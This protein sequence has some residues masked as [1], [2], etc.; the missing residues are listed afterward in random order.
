MEKIIRVQRDQGACPRSH[1]MSEAELVNSQAR[2][3]LQVRGQ[4]SLKRDR[5]DTYRF[6]FA[7][8]LEPVLHR[9]R[10]QPILVGPLFA[11]LDN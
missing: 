5:T 1:S 8:Y 7:L 2:M 9:A 4:G 6:Y 11:R 3:S 10:R